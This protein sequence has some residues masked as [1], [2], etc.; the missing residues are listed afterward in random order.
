VAHVGEVF[1]VTEHGS[2]GDEKHFGQWVKHAPDNA[3]VGQGG[4][5]LFE[6]QNVLQI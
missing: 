5:E 6:P 1:A 4:K 3:R 2:E